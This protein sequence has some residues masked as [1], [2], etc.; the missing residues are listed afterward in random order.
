M[1]A[2]HKAAAAA[3]DAAYV[4]LEGPAESPRLSAWALGTTPALLQDSNLNIPSGTQLSLG[5]Q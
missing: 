5:F 2:K 3:L 1:M 4:L